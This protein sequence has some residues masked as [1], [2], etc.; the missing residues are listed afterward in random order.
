MARIP[1]C[2]LDIAQPSG[3]H[4]PLI[5]KKFC[6]VDIRNLNNGKNTFLPSNFLHWLGCLSRTDG[7]A[8]ARLYVILAPIGCL[9]DWWL[10]IQR[11]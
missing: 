10:H 2:A 7:A 9:G 6:E 3:H 8:A 4:S 5:L 11:W 1:S